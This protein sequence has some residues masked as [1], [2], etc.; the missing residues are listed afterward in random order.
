[1]GIT[2]GKTMTYYNFIDGAWEPSVSG[3]VFEN[4]NPADRDDVA[5][6]LYTIRQRSFLLN[7]DVW[8]ELLALLHRYPELMRF[9]RIERREA[10]W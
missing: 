5:T 3:D 9:I 2:T 4:R 8:P 1:M 6:Q 7:V 10:A